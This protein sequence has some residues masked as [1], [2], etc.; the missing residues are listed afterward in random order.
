MTAADG[1]LLGFGLALVWI[2]L[3]VGAALLLRRLR[4]RRLETRWKAETVEWRP[5]LLPNP[6][7]CCPVHGPHA[8]AAPPV[9]LDS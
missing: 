4:L 2:A 8:E 5:V 9:T 3:I 7:T 6:C 1:V